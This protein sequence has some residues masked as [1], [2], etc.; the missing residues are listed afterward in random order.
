M[1]TL[2]RTTAAAALVL[3]A[4]LP[5]AACSDDGDAAGTSATG[6][7]AS[8]EE[9]LAAAKT[10]LDATS[11][12]RLTLATDDTPDSDAYLSEASGVIVA[13][14]PAFQGTAS[15]TFEG[16][17][18]S[19]VEIVSVGGQVY[20]QLFGAFQDFN[21]PKCVPDPAGLLDPDTGFGT[22]LTEAQQVSRGEAVRGGADN[23]EI[24]T[25]FTATV[26][27]DA[28]QNLL[29]C[30]PGEEFVATFNLDEDGLLQTADIQGEFFP[31]G[32]E[33]TYTVAVE[34]Y[35]VEQD[36]AKP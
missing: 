13:D 9:A 19:D 1:S 14:P 4:S 10:A 34:E 36:I 26:P 6:D 31:G 27:G 3:T 2:R 11:G 30:A 18:A 24:L 7:E 25:P 12:V 17:P 8:P 16:I 32:G 5:L 28:V 15:G 20:A 33:L 23:S 22:V 35:D 21:L 29:P